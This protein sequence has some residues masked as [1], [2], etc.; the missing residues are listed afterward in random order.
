[1]R[2]CAGPAAIA[3]YLREIEENLKTRANAPKAGKLSIRKCGEADIP[4][5]IAMMAELG[6]PITAGGGGPGGYGPRPAH[7]SGYRTGYLHGTRTLQV[8]TGVGSC[9]CGNTMRFF[10]PCSRR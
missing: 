6:I 5:V 2:E 7:P 8:V 1:M 10:P 4:G 9:K 3:E